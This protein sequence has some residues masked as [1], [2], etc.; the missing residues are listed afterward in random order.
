M[1][2]IIMHVEFDGREITREQLEDG[3]DDVLTSLRERG[4]DLGW[5]YF[6]SLGE[7]EAWESGEEAQS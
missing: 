3:L 5:R 2:K 7:A 4:L 6:S 1:Q